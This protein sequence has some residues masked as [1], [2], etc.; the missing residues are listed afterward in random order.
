MTNTIFA[1]VLWRNSVAFKLKTRNPYPLRKVRVKRY[2]F[3]PVVI[4]FPVKPWEITGLTRRNFKRFFGWSRMRIYLL[5]WVK[6][7]LVGSVQNKIPCMSPS[8]S[9]TGSSFTINYSRL[10]GAVTFQALLQPRL[11]CVDFF[12]HGMAWH[13]TL[14]LSEVNVRL[15]NSGCVFSYVGYGF[16]YFYSFGV[17]W[18]RLLRTLCGFFILIRLWYSRCCSW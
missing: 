14:F 11:F 10:V 17:R 12:F 18:V 9:D 1:T 8:S 4:L 7:S 3:G 15:H 13:L 5:T 6:S 2:W 16:A